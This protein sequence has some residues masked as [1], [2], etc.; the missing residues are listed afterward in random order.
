MH[1]YIVPCLKKEELDTNRLR[2][3]YMIYVSCLGG[4][5]KEPNVG[6]GDFFLLSL[7]V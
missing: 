1:L 2:C 6:K 4:M 7:A 5:T 3:A